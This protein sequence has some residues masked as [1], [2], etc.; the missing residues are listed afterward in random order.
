MFGKPECHLLKMKLK[1]KFKSKYYLI[2]QS[3]YYFVN[4]A[5]REG[6]PLEG[7][8]LA[9]D[10]QCTEDEGDPLQCNRCGVVEA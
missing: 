3:K 9:L 5:D 8:E 7:G 6:Q 1:F 4:F 10:D 2:K